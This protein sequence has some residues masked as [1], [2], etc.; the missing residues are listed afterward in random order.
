MP[1]ELSSTVL[2]CGE[3]QHEPYARHGECDWARA[4]SILQR[5]SAQLARHLVP[6]DQY[7]QRPSLGWVAC[8]H[9]R[10]GPPPRNVAHLGSVGATVVPDVS[11]QMTHRT[12]VLQ[13]AVKSAPIF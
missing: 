12:G 11:F 10:Y 4:P 8:L 1:N 2:P 3:L 6:D 13:D 5:Q 9:I 7:Q